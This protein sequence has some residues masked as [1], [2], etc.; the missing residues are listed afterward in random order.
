MTPIF[1]AVELLGGPT[2]VAALLG[3]T[4]QAVCFWR[5]GERKFP[6]EHCATVEQATSGVVTRRDLR[7]DD[8]AAIWPE[9][10]AE[11]KEA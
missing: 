9:L 5:D 2:K 6:I 7:P 10:V 1:K 8:W 4:T 3:V 11:K